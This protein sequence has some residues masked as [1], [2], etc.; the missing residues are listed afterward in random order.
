MFCFNNSWVHWAVAHEFAFFC[1]T[2]VSSLSAVSWGAHSPWNSQYEPSMYSI[3]LELSKRPLSNSPALHR[4]SNRTSDGAYLRFHWDALYKF[5]E[6]INTLSGLTLFCCG[7][8]C[9]GCCLEFVDLTIQLKAF[10][11]LSLDLDEFRLVPVCL[12]RCTS[13]LDCSALKTLQRVLWIVITDYTPKFSSNGSAHDPFIE[14]SICY[15][16]QFTSSSLILVFTWVPEPDNN[17]PKKLYCSG[18][19]S[20]YII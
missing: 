20:Q 12:F 2:S 15:L 3:V 17:H 6:L 11:L 4:Y 19:Y 1:Q 8:I 5:S 10:K 18:T 16:P 9:L 13:L 14:L 7:F